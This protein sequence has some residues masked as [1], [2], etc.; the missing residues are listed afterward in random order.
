MAYSSLEIISSRFAFTSVETFPTLA[1]VPMR[2]HTSLS[3]RLI[4]EWGGGQG[5]DGRGN[6]AKVLR[7]RVK[8]VLANVGGVVSDGTLLARAC[9]EES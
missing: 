2:W 9:C 3:G 8:S 4:L 6:R 1:G 5:E 7:L